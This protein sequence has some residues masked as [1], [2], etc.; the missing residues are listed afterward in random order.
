MDY[1]EALLS[2]ETPPGAY[3][4]IIDMY[5]YIINPN[6]AWHGTDQENGHYPCTGIYL[7]RR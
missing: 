6:F 2:G 7:H 3:T 5:L 4:Y 1:I